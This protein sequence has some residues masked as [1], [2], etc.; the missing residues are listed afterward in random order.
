[1]A[2]YVFYGDC[3]YDLSFEKFND[4]E[5]AVEFIECEHDSYENFIVLE[6]V[7]LQINKKFSLGN[8]E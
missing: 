8:V 3:D 4:K 5:K 2:I 1:M 7:E 6:G